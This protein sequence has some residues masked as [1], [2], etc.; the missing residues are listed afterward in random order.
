MAMSTN[1]SA[2]LLATNPT[3]ARPTVLFSPLKESCRMR[4]NSNLEWGYLQFYKNRI[5]D[6]KA[7]ADISFRPDKCAQNNVTSLKDHANISLKLASYVM[8]PSGHDLSFLGRPPGKRV[9]QT[10]KK[11][12]AERFRHP[13]PR[14]LPSPSYV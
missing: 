2:S 5:R 6:L 10:R 8:V 1:P 7:T 14:N 9:R 12:M 4:G 13:P 3:G 11:L